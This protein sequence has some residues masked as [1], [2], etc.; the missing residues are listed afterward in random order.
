MAGTSLEQE[1]AEVHAMLGRSNIVAEWRMWTGSLSA[2]YD[3][4]RTMIETVSELKG[5]L[6][7][8]LSCSGMRVHRSGDGTVA[9]IV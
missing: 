2:V 1:A 7:R 3:G 6:E 5:S 8:C 4:A 9:L